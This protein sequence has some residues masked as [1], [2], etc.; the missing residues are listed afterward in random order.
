MGK[1]ISKILG[2][3]LVALQLLVSVIFC[4]ILYVSNFLELDNIL[5]VIL[6]LLILVLI[7]LILQRWLISG[8][9][10]K[11][12]ALF[13]IL[14][15]GYGSNMLLHTNTMLSD[16]T[17]GTKEVDEINYYVL[18]NDPAQ[19]IADA[20]DYTF[21][22][23]GS[24]D[25]ENT[26]YAVTEAEGKTGSP[27]TLQEYDDIQAL[28]AALYAKD[29][30]AAIINQAYVDVLE[31]MEDYSDFSTET[32][33]LETVSKESE[34]VSAEEFL[35]ADEICTT[36]FSVYISGCDQAGSISTKG[37]SDV[38]I[39]ATINPITKQVIL[40]S[41]PRDYYIPLSIS[42]GQKD[43]LTHAGIYGVDV[44]MDTLGKLYDTDLS[45]YFKVNFTGFKDIV[46]A[47]GG[48]EVDSDVA[49]TAG[50]QA[51][52]QSEKSS[53]T[54]REGSN[55]LDGGA[56]LAFARERHAFASGDRQRGVN[57]MKV[58]E[59]V[60]KK[61]QSVSLLA[62]YADVMKSISGS[63]ETNLTS[64]Q[65]QA[66]VKM[67]MDDMASWNVLTYSVSGTDAK[68]STYSSPGHK[69]Y[70]M[71]P[72]DSTVEKAIELVD[73][74]CNGEKLTRA[75]LEKSAKSSGKDSDKN[76][77]DEDSGEEE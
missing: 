41:T 14:G 5:I 47:L 69:A 35:P 25:R 34:V 62:N 3:I 61:V 39:I 77:E 19:S 42:G 18:A 46:N 73:M 52:S 29:I 58:I 57:Q 51:C 27:L 48:I 30:G 32:R 54:F 28:A 1:I 37:R 72:D 63:F 2:L 36:P 23:L 26:D 74:V 9:V 17:S 70:V 64:K 43:K 75:D 13:I 71:I 53:Y 59:G 22:V 55:D 4:G 15:L 11:F 33:V 24:M 76:P 31:D 10:G 21:G 16:I 40:I 45:L 68:E 20:A 49:F 8:I 56:A 12:L 38:N 50:W 66:L 67:Q 60:L 44:S 65:I 7:N 6:V